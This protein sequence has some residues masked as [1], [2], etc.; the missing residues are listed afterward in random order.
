MA[1]PAQLGVKLSALLV[2]IKNK[3][4]GKLDSSARAAD[5]SKLEGL[6]LAQV[7]AKTV[8]DNL[9]QVNGQKGEAAFFTQDGT[10][11]AMSGAP[12][13]TPIRF[14]SDDAAITALKNETVTFASV[15]NTWQRISHN[16]TLQFPANVA[17]MNSWSY[18]SGTDAI[19]S[20]VN[21]ATLIGMISLDRFDAYTFE[22]TFSSTATDDDV[23]GMCAAFKRANGREYTLGVYADGLGKI[24]C[25]VNFNQ[26]A[27]N[28]QQTLWTQSLGVPAQ[29]WN[30]DGLMK[31]GVRVKIVRTAAGMLEITSTQAD[32]TPWPT[33]VFTTVAIPAMFLGAC[34]IGYLAQSQANSTWKNYQVPVAKRDII[35]TRDLTVWRWNNSLSQWTNAGKANNPAVL[36]PGRL[37]KNTEGTKGSYYLDFEGNFITLGIANQP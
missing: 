16:N 9:G 8:T 7:M 15:F 32:G 37:Y 20:T 34:Q 18:D 2:A 19:Q 5:S 13:L 36:P 29:N 33:P 10:P 11:G 28:G 26:G 22:T 27:A 6:S 30:A 14:A 17:E 12:M 21:S 24:F 25:S 31:P 23:I 35:D 3:I 4:N 1:T